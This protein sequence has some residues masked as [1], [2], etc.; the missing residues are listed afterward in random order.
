[1]ARPKGGTC[2]CDGS[3]KKGG[4]VDVYFT[5]DNGEYIFVRSTVANIPS[6][7]AG[8]AYGCLLQAI[9]NGALYSNTGGATSCTFTIVSTV[10]AGSVTLA[11]LAAGITP[12]HVVK[13]AGTATGGTTATRAYTVT[14]AAATD[15]ATA[16]IRASTNAAS[17]Q[18]AVLTTD[19][20]TVTFS[21][22]PGASTTVDYSILRAAS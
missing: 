12:S 7:V 19:T 15:V 11:T 14:G 5:N 13:Y 10:T 16:V 3:I 4:K 18:K 9:D 1:M 22:D 6:G 20:L 8:Y 17:I 21:T 2:F